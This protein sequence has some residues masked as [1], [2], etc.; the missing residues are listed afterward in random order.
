MTVLFRRA[1]GASSAGSV[2]IRF[3]HTNDMPRLPAFCRFLLPGKCSKT[4][5]DARNR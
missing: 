2:A 5:T 3:I 1:F 4:L